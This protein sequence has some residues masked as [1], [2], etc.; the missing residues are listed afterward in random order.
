MR[1][2]GIYRVI[3]G[4]MKGVTEMMKVLFILITALVLLFSFGVSGYISFFKIPMGNRITKMLAF[5][6]ISTATT[7]VTFIICLAI[8]WPPI[9]M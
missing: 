2:P 7:A 3:L 8:I 5:L 1:G 4:S 6:M 9:K